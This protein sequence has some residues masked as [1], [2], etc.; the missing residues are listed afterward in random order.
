M[1]GVIVVYKDLSVGTVCCYS[2][3]ALIRFL[4]NSDVTVI[5]LWETEEKW[6]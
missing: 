3:R 2:T 5:K 4:R 1:F 6:A